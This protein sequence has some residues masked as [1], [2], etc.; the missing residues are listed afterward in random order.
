[1]E[2]LWLAQV[3]SRAVQQFSEALR[4]A[5]K[6]ALT[7]YCLGVVLVGLGQ[8]EK[9]IEH[10]QAAIDFDPQYMEAHFQ[11]ANLLMRGGRYES[12]GREY[13]TV[14]AADPSN[15]FAGLMRAIAMARVK[16]YRG[17]R[18]MLEQL[19]A[20]MPANPEI[21]GALARLLAACPDDGIRNGPRALRVIQEVIRAQKSANVDQ[22]QTLAMALA[23]VHDF[24][25]AASVQRSTI[26]VLEREKQPDMIPVLREDLS[27]YERGRPCRVPW[28]SDDPIFFPVPSQLELPRQNVPM[29][30]RP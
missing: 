15:S 3:M 2:L 11:L 25:K 30:A 13:A 29:A 24:E 10:L 26:S 7:H 18:V 6:N 5:P 28:R 27:L 1:L 21:A 17:A 9:A 19:Y 22:A 14:S 12:A 16:D 20:G 4:I 8:D 23:E